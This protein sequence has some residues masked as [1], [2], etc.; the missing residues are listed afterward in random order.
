MNE[1]QNR[2]QQLKRKRQEL[3]NPPEDERIIENPKPLINLNEDQPPSVV[4]LDYTI[5]FCLIIQADLEKLISKS[6][7]AKEYEK[8]QFYSD[9]IVELQT[10]PIPTIQPKVYLFLHQQRV[11]TKK[12]IKWG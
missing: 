8:A 5:V 7:K 11:K 4:Q 1:F 6:I 12:K 2:F 9:K 3:N 10:K